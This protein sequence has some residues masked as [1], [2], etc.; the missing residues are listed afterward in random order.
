MS[1]SPG[2]RKASPL[3]LPLKLLAL[4]T[5]GFTGAALY[6]HPEL[7]PLWMGGLVLG[8]LGL[9]LAEWRVADL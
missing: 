8:G 9:G 5:W 6:L 2:A 4:L 3:R 1:S 7:D